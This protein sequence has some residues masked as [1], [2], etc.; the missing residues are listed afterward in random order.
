MLS[1]ETHWTNT[2]NVRIDCHLVLCSFT[3][4]VTGVLRIC[5]ASEDIKSLQIAGLEIT[6]A[7]LASAPGI[8]G[9]GSTGRAAPSGRMQ[10]SSF[11]VSKESM[12]DRQCVSVGQNGVTVVKEHH[13]SQ[14]TPFECES[15]RHSPHSAPRDEPEVRVPLI[16]V[17][18]G[19]SG[20]KGDSANVGI[21]ARHSC[22]YPYL[23]RELTESAVVAH[24]ESLVST[25]SNYSFKISSVQRYELPNVQGLN[26]LLNG[27]LGGG[28]ASSLF[29]D[30][31]GKTFA[32]RLLTMHVSVPARLLPST[33]KL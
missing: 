14:H 23:L 20:D 31:Q 7:A 19:R 3:F 13:V 27:D 4:G 9:V 15:K 26:F 28:G 29:Y 21:I 2:T 1:E 33:A 17:A 10:Q 32:Q 12:A 24:M 6:P 11:L 25:Q 30:K 22:F 8:S 16:T 5:F 18:Y